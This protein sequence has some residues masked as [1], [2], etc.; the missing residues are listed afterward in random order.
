MHHFFQPFSKKNYNTL[1]SHFTLI[2]TKNLSMG[3]Q[4]RGGEICILVLLGRKNEVFIFC[5]ARLRVRK[6]INATD[7]YACSCRS[8]HHRNKKETSMRYLQIIKYKHLHKERE[9][10]SPSLILVNNSSQAQ[11]ALAFKSFQ[12]SLTIPFWSFSQ[13]TDSFDVTEKRRE[14]E[15]VSKGLG[16]E[17]RE[18]NQWKHCTYWVCGKRSAPLMLK[19]SYSGAARTNCPTSLACVCTLHETYTICLGP[20]LTSWLMKASLWGEE[21]SP[22]KPDVSV[23]RGSAKCSSRST[24]SQPLLGGLERQ[25]KQKV[26]QREVRTWG[27]ITELKVDPFSPPATTHS[28]TTVVFSLG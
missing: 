22:T 8:Q 18:W 19:I 17:V 11:I 5:N 12:F 4:G 14:T 23:E 3:N 28:I 10:W 21:N 13:D 9:E 7:W 24:H 6:M 16:R 26:V 20:N 25:R 15:P 27:T 2:S 1:L